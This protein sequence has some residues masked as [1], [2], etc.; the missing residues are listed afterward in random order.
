MRIVSERTAMGAA[1]ALQ[2]SLDA[3]WSGEFERAVEALLRE[4][5]R[6]IEVCCAQVNFVSSAGM[7]ALLRM[8]KAVR[9]AGGALR[10][11]GVGEGLLQTLR[12]MKLEAVL[13]TPAVAPASV[14]PEVHALPGLQV[15]ARALGGAGFQWRR[16]GGDASVSRIRLASDEA[17]FGVG[18]LGHGA[19]DHAGELVG[20]GSVA[21]AMPSLGGHADLLA[22]L[23][24]GPALTL[25]DAAV[26]RGRPSM[27]L[28]FDAT[29]GR[30]PLDALLRLATHRAG[31]A[32][33]VVIAGESEGV[34]GASANRSPGAADFAA[35]LATSD[36]ARR[37]LRWIGTPSFRGDLLIVVGVAAPGASAGAW[38]CFLR[39]H[40]EGLMAHVHG[41]V[42]P[43]RPLH[44]DEPDPGAVMHAALDGVVPRTVLHLVRDG[45]R[46][47][48]VQSAFR[49]G[50]MWIGP[51]LEGVRA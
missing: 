33:C 27:H 29:E 21:A 8:H 48:A 10:L 43:F 5:V 15:R 6:D 11:S 50:V 38:R 14:Q 51:L 22:D 7:G 25:L 42:A 31:G 24:E 12:L 45:R 28:R 4:G 41:V 36:G 2:G 20:V 35:S 23:A 17:M 39:P 18:C 19:V 26:L 49:R 13:L 37:S 46:E 1:L 40:G 30:V 9:A 47:P 44:L 16:V 32:A 34:V 3:T